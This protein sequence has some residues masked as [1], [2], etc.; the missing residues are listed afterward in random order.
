[1]TW[2]SWA[3]GDA[4][5]VV[6]FVSII[7]IARAVGG[8]G[9]DRIGSWPRIVTPGGMSTEGVFAH[10]YMRF[11]EQIMG[12]C[13]GR[14]T[15]A[16]TSHLIAC[17]RYFSTMLTFWEQWLAADGY[18]RLDPFARDAATDRL[19]A[20]CSDLEGTPGSTERKVLHAAAALKITPA[21]AAQLVRDYDKA[22]VEFVDGTTSPLHVA[23]GAVGAEHAE[24]VRVFLDAFPTTKQHTDDRGLTVLQIALLGSARLNVIQMLVDAWPHLA[25]LPM[26]STF[27]NGLNSEE[28]MGLEG[29]TPL[30][31]AASRNAEL[32]VIFFLCRDDPDSQLSASRA[33]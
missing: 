7:D 13:R 12:P 19:L 25:R 10:K 31:L 23:A 26:P 8:P 24:R 14:G 30:Q 6:S 15:I 33:N 2:A 4:R 28:F 27:R 16:A 20:L 1:I 17:G 3:M 18:D 11:Q 5:G 9:Q 22:A 21:N 32:D 29:L